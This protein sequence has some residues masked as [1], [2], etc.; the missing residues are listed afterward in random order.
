MF[1][2]F[3][4]C[5]LDQRFDGVGVFVEENVRGQP[6]GMD[7]ANRAAGVPRDAGIGEGGHANTIDS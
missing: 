6:L 7:G 5:P 4:R 1:S 3:G 2:A